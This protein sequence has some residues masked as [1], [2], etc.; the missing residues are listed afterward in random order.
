LMP[1]AI[2]SS[3]SVIPNRRRSSGGTLEWVMVAGW[4]TRVST[5]PRLS[6]REQ[7]RRDLRKVR[8]YS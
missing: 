3:P 1:T 6:A 8:A 4:A 5:P 2:R 7:S